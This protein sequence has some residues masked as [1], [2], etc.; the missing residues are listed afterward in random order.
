VH[1][2]YPS[3]YPPTHPDFGRPRSEER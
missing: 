2:L 1:Y 3:S